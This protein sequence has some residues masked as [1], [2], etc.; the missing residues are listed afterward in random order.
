MFNHNKYQLCVDCFC[1]NTNQHTII[2][3]ETSCAATRKQCYEMNQDQIDLVSQFIETIDGD[4]SY[5]TWKK[6]YLT[7]RVKRFLIEQYNYQCLLKHGFQNVD[8]PVGEIMFKKKRSKT[9]GG[10]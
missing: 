1:I 10:K 6:S 2:I 7:N 4:G 5:H 3:K 9:V 8:D